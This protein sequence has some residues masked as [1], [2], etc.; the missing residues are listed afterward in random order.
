LPPT[1]VTH[2]NRHPAKGKKLKMRVK[3]TLAPS[4]TTT[5]NRASFPAPSSL[6]GAA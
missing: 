1:G 6:A 2:P 4:S 3:R 5:P